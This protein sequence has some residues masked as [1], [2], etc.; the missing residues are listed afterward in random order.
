V[1][2]EKAVAGVGR[3][4]RSIRRR[5]VG[6]VVEQDQID[7]IAAVEHAIEEG[8]IAFG[9]I[10]RAE[11]DEVGAI[12]DPPGAVCGGQVQVHDTGIFRRP[13]IDRAERPARNFLVLPDRTKRPARKGRRF[14]PVNLNVGDARRSRRRGNGLPHQETHEEH[15]RGR[16]RAPVLSP[17]F[18]PS[19]AART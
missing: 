13:G 2:H 12:G 7:L 16:H 15:E 5:T 6:H 9:R 14:N 11:D 18:A 1:A 8:A 4:M 17:L 19:Q 3:S 10:A